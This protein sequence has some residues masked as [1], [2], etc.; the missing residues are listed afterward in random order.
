MKIAF[1]EFKN[2]TIKEAIT[3]YNASVELDGDAT[4]SA[5]DQLAYVEPVPAD[6][7]TAACELVKSGQADTLI[8][9]ADYSSRDV[10]LAARDHFGMAT[11]PPLFQ[12]LQPDTTT[13]T[14]FS[15]LAVMRRNEEVYL[16][17][18]MAACKRPT[19]ERMLEIIYQTYQTARLLLP[20]PRLALLS[21]SSFGSG[22]KDPSIDLWREVL[23]EFEAY[24]AALPAD[25]PPL[26]ID[27]EMQLDT[28]ICP[29]VAAK[30]AGD[31]PV[32]GR[33]NV[34]IAP[35]LNSGN[36]LYKAFERLAGFTVAGPLLQGFNFP[37]S[38]LSRGSTATDIALTIDV[39]TRLFNTQHQ[40]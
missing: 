35:D 21:F 33:A 25:V 9:G 19:K 31:S 39:L 34:L 38:D 37:L 17:A 22:G 4:D 26:L 6:D 32:A 23:A 10:I 24:N 16:L 1:P 15:G 20:E 12:L 28:A 40:N 11:L 14:T 3:L 29:E 5:A 13:Y 7:L 36:L 30:K 27:G 2:P 8:A 18:D